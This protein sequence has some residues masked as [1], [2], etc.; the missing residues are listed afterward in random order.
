M[1]QGHKLTEVASEKVAIIGSDPGQAEKVAQELGYDRS[2]A[3]AE[4]RRL[5]IDHAA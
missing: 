1:G 4:A 3:C 2:A 5:G